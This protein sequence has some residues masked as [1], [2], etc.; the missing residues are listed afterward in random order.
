MKTNTT[1]ISLL[2]DLRAYLCSLLYTLAYRLT[3]G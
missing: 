3:F 1:N 2:R